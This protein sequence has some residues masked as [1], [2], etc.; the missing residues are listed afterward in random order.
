MYPNTQYTMAAGGYF[1]VLI[2]WR[3][4]KMNRI[5]VQL[6]VLVFDNFLSEA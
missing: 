6:S 3:R 1:N 4:R 2:Y 5:K